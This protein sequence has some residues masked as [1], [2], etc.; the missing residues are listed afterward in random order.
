MSKTGGNLA[1]LTAIGLTLVGI[2]LF[3]LFA[4]LP[5]IEREAPARREAFRRSVVQA[6]NATDPNEFRAEICPRVADRVY[7]CVFDPPCW[8]SIAG[9]PPAKP[10][11]RREFVYDENGE[12]IAV[13]ESEE[14]CQANVDGRVG[15]MVPK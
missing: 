9:P 2:V 5:V 7:R 11:V 4:I 15:G 3:V 13:V 10:V 14:P 6:I 12:P 1:L 8:V